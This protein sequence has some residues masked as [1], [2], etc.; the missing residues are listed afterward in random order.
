MVGGEGG[1][2]EEKEHKAKR[3]REIENEKQRKQKE[4]HNEESVK[5]KIKEHL[6]KIQEKKK[7]EDTQRKIEEERLAREKKHKFKKIKNQ[8][9]K[10]EKPAEVSRKSFSEQSQTSAKVGNEHVLSKSDQEDEIRLKRNQFKVKQSL[11]LKKNKTSSRSD[12][13]SENNQKISQSSQEFEDMYQ[14][15]RTD[16]IKSLKNLR[17][18]SSNSDQKSE[19]Q[20]PQRKLIV[21]YNQIESQIKKSDTQ[22]SGTIY[23]EV[24]SCNRKNIK[25]NEV[26]G[27]VAT[28]LFD[29]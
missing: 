9:S 7:V 19:Y 20:E 6:I 5:Q 22:K 10:H 27:L 2:R 4:F 12:D 21:G 25:I 24:T 3:Q 14:S 8:F 18:E 28:F 16:E 11:S 29:V 13:V 15:L 23:E 26:F 17:K 1:R